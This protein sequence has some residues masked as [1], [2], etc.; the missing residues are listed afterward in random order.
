M[1]KNTKAFSGF[2]VDDVERRAVLRQTLGL[3]TE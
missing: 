3:K 2:A 1:F